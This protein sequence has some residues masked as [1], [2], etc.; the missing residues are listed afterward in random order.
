MSGGILVEGPGDED[1]IKGF[2]KKIG[3]QDVEVFPP[4]HLGGSGNGINNVLGFIPVLINQLRT[5]IIDKAAIVVDADYTGING[6]F[7]IRRK[8]ITDLLAV[9]GYAIP[10]NPPAQAGRG[11]IFF[12]SLGQEPIGLFIL[13]DHQNDGMLENF[14]KTLVVDSPY[15]A[16][17]EHA[18]ATVG[19]L[20]NVLFNQQLH[21]AKAEIGTFLAWQRR[22][23]SYASICLLDNIFD[24]SA[25]SAQDFVSWVNKAV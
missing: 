16:V 11:E 7:S 4:K 8:Q 1:F 5:G 10:V 23:P 22:P 17:L 6:G 25:A 2:L 18:T 9:D 19:A 3:K 14:L 21:T 24:A 20:P 13:P 12:N 15:T